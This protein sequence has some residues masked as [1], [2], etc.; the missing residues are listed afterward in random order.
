[1]ANISSAPHDTELTLIDHGHLAS[2]TDLNRDHQE[3]CCGVEWA[4][5]V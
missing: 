2:T 5:I 1:M 3:A 4:N